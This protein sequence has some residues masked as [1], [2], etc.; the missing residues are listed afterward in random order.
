MVAQVRSPGSRGADGRSVAADATTMAAWTLVSRVTGLGRLLVLGAVLGQTFFANL[1]STGAVLPALVYELVV[2]HFI[3]SLFVPPLVERI[4]RGD[5]QGTSQLAGSL[6]GLTALVFGA[7]GLAVAAA[8]P[9]VLRALLAGVDD[10]AVREAQLALGWPML[11][12]LAPAAAVYGM[13]ATATAVQ[14]AHHRYALASAAP[15]I[16]N[17]G[18]I[19]TLV[20]SG[21]LYG[22]GLEIGQVSSE[23]AMFVSVGVTASIC[24]H[25]AVQWWGV[26]SLGIGFRPRLR[27]REP[28][29]QGVIRRAVESLGTAGL[30][31]SRSVGLLIATGSVAGG[32]IAVQLAQAFANTVIALSAKPVAASLLPRLSRLVQAGDLGEFRTVFRDGKALFLFLALPAALL[33]ATLARPVAE[34]IARGELATDRGVAMVAIALAALAP[35]MLTE[36][37]FQISTG[38]AYSRLDVR[39]PLWA[40]ALGVLLAAVGFVAAL[41]MESEHAVLLT[42]SFSLVG[43][44]AVSALVLDRALLKD[45]PPGP[46]R[47]DRVRT[48]PAALAAAAAAMVA[49]SWLEPHTAAPVQLALAG[50]LAAVIYLGIGVATGSP[51]LAELRAM[52]R[53]PDPAVPA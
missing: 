8:G 23:H 34:I 31:S 53:P 14:F 52:R 29:V 19:G 37:G 22:R 3:T 17:I 9:L 40:M 28:A 45:L 20:A 27:W 11:A 47:A 25:G 2:G 42:A 48:V 7:A 16:E 35:L 36:G 41:T 43:S 39:R 30:S 26:R 12:V 13:I 4:D 15:A 1:V 21:L 44:T 18:I 46:G 6:L 10:P 51:Q 50:A 49:A 5:R 38:A 33:F 32:V 24:A